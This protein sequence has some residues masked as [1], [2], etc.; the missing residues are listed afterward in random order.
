[1]FEGKY[2]YEKF[3][4]KTAKEKSIVT[5]SIHGDF[6]ITP[7]D[8]KSGYGCRECGIERCITSRKKSKE[9]WLQEFGEIYSNKYTYILPQNMGNKSKITVV[10]PDHGEFKVRASNH[11]LGH[12]CQKCSLVERSIKRRSTLDEWLVD[13]KETHANFYTYEYCDS[14]EGQDVLMKVTCPAHGVFK[15]KAGSHKAGRGCTTC[16][17]HGYDRLSP[18]HLYILQDGDLTK[19]GIT[20]KL[21]SL[22]RLRDINRKSGLNFAVYHTMYSENGGFILE[23]EQTS[24]KHFRKLYDQPKHSFSGSTECFYDLDPEIARLHIEQLFLQLNEQHSSEQQAV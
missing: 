24:L 5:C 14:Y 12:S 13:C 19:I 16:A 20:N 10:C 1:M 6:L 22:G 15:I 3:V 9:L 21:P 17:Q 7:S 11:K 23:L 4:Y 18:S 8:H 2:T